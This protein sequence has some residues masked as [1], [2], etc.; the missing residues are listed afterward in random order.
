MK[1]S[2]K[3][4]SSTPGTVS[5]SCLLL[6]ATV[7]FV[8]AQPNKA[9]KGYERLFIQPKHYVV[10]YTNRPP[11]IDGDIDDKI[12][13]AAAWTDEFRDIE[14]E[15]SSRPLPYY[16]T[17]AKMLWDTSY[18]YIAA[19]MKDK[20]VWA[21][22][23]KHDEVVYYD[24][25]FEVFIDPNNSAQNY[26]E[27]EINALNTIFDLYLA[28]PY[29]SGASGMLISWDCKDLLHAVRI[30]GTL[31]DPS[32]E[33]RGWTVEMAIPFNSISHQPKDSTLWR[34][35]FSRVEWDVKTVGGKYV[36]KTGSN[37]K[38]LPENNWVWS[39]QGAIDMHRPERWAYLMFSKVE[40]GSV[41]P[42][43]QLPYSELQRRYL[44]LIFYK[45][46]DWRRKNNT[47]TDSFKNLKLDSVIYINGIRNAVVI[48]AT[49][50][51]FTALISD[52]INSQA[53]VNN[54]GRAESR[55]IEIT[56]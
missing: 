38:P 33:D 21:N 14:G 3:I 40:A 23:A 32:D 31:N 8:N 41:L 56:K 50:S 35:N 42:E 52:S 19:D 4:N 47:F 7:T 1:S 49:S 15:L 48:E 11:V 37:G 51:Q 17:R 20:H 6:L 9:F 12:W 5:L 22:L 25:D 26:F 43:F 45:Q 39:P 10:G 34:F 54:Y 13:E 18:L 16:A 53:S 27:I 2:V 29:R 55:N 44:W 28:K 46:Q 30:Q 36:K 24:N